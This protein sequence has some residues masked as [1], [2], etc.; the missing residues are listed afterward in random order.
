MPNQDVADG[1]IV[2]RVVE[3]QCDPTGVTENDLDIFA[4]QAIQQDLC[5]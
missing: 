5:A 1:A 4:L 3:R 2:Q